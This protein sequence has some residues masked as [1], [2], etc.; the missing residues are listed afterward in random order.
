MNETNYIRNLL[1]HLS[2]QTRAG[3]EKANKS[4]G[5]KTVQETLEIRVGSYVNFISRC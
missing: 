4:V 1:T 2:S 3:P 5:S